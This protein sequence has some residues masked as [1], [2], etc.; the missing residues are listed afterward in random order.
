M[1]NVSKFRSR[2][3]GTG[4]CE[5]RHMH[6]KLKLHAVLQ[7]CKAEQ[8][9]SVIRLLIP[10]RRSA[11]YCDKYV[12]LSA[13]ITRK[14]HDRTSP[15]WYMLSVVADRSPLR[16]DML[17]TSGFMDDVMFSYHEANEPDSIKNLVADTDNGV[18]RADDGDEPAA[19]G[20]SR[21][22]CP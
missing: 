13:C 22:S 3:Y 12:C 4:K 21:G 7:R 19:V 16:C 10:L 6:I 1:T 14:S 15:I 2:K 18:P 17:C 11:K 5:N 20:A 8:T 9:E